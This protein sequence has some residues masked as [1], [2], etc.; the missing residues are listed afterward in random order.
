MLRYI[1]YKILRIL[2]LV[3]QK[4]FNRSILK[5]RG[6]YKCLAN[7]KLFDKKWYKSN[8]PDVKKDPLKHYLKKGWKEG[9][10][11]SPFF[12]GNKYLQAYHDVKAAGLNPLLHYECFGKY[13]GRTNFAS[14]N[15]LL[16]NMVLM[17]RL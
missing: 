5:Y 16:M 14:K 4:K 8:Y 9:R 17:S 15:A 1:F 7:S 6:G 10:Q 13:E 2:G 12:D 3:S 11:P